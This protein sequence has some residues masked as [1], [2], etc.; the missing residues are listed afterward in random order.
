[1]KYSN[2]SLWRR[3]ISSP[4]AVIVLAVAV[5]IL[6]RAAIN[7]QGKVQ[8]SAAKLEQAQAEYARLV[9]RQ[10]DIAR[11]VDYLSTDQGVEA[12]IR[13]KYHAVKD[14]ERV[15][16]IVDSS[17]SANVRQ[18]ATGIATSTPGFWRRLLRAIGL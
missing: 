7:I 5:F 6:A 13:T 2:T 9:Q 16:V 14:G 15:A 8:V 1:M 12:E 10:Q 3:F 17:Q 4:F 11:R 18:S